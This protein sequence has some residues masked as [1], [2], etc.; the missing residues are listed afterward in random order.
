MAIP[1]ILVL[2]AASLVAGTAQA[3]SFKDK[4]PEGVKL[5][6]TWKLDPAR[7]D[8]P[9]REIE[10]ADKAEI[11]RRSREIEDRNRD[12]QDPPWDPLD[13]STSRDRPRNRHD[14]FP[15]RRNDGVT[16]EGTGIDEKWGTTRTRSASNDALL[17]LDPNPATLT[18]VDS[19]NRVSVSE[20][21]LENEC[22]VGEVRPIADPFGDGNVRCGWR[23]R[24]WVVETTRIER[25]KRTD[26]FELS[27]DGKVLR[28]TS[29]A[30]GPKIPTV[31]VDRTYTLVSAQ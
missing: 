17:G 30:A 2:V 23:G 26:R 24:V 25:F 21:K 3:A 13:P 1:P 19:G 29:T 16:I 15:S 28:Y 31:K 8:D 22:V 18:I 14:P 10:K 6:G 27:K 4:A 20:D 5:T 9:A 7:S 11:A 12:L